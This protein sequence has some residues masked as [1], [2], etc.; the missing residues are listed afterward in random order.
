MKCDAECTIYYVKLFLYLEVEMLVIISGQTNAGKDTLVKYLCENY[1]LEGV[2][3]YTDRPI[4]HYE[5]D[6]REHYF[7]TREEFDEL[8]KISDVLAYTEIVDEEK[9]RLDPYYH[10]YRYFTDAKDVGDNNVII[11]DVKGY[12]YFQASS[13]PHVSIYISCNEGIRRERAIKRGDDINVLE[14]RCRDENAQFADALTKG[15]DL[16]VSNDGSIEDMYKV[17]DIFMKS[18]GGRKI[19]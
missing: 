19:C 11:L 8:L 16:Y 17:V 10:G 6:G 1:N 18:V 9:K 5:K 4:R 14:K 7:R 2:C 15:Y 3:T 13:I 12:D